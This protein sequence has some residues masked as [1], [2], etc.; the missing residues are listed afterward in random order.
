MI[1]DAARVL[2]FQ[3]AYDEEVARLVAEQPLIDDSLIEDREARRFQ[4]QS[5]DR[6]LFFTALDCPNMR[7]CIRASFEAQRSIR[8]RRCLFHRFGRERPIES[9]RLAAELQSSS[10]DVPSKPSC[11]SLRRT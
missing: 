2:A 10:A 6:I 8:R 9:A 11:D 4:L 1:A 7:R 3:R 5:T